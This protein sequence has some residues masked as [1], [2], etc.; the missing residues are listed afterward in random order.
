MTRLYS[1]DSNKQMFKDVVITK[2]INQSIDRI[3]QYNV[4][5]EMDYLKNKEDVPTHLPSHYHYMLA[6]FAA[7]RCFESDERYYEAVERRNEFESLL[8]LLVADIQSGNIVIKD[9]DGEIVEDGT[10]AL[11]F[12]KDV[13]FKNYGGSDDTFL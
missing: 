3:K 7:S 5:E 12:V 2:Y 11:D 8:E 10:N 6:L 9:G 13:Y 1:R 4:F